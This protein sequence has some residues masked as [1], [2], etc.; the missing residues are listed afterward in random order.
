[1]YSWV[2]VEPI[3]VKSRVHKRSNILHFKKKMGEKLFWEGGICNQI[4]NPLTYP[5]Y[6]NK[7]SCTRLC[8]G[9]AMWKYCFQ[10]EILEA[11]ILPLRELK[12]HSGL[13][14]LFVKDISIVANIHRIINS[15]P[16]AWNWLIQILRPKA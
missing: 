2:P 5:L 13:F 10:N 11:S 16:L 15:V 7:C 1:M 12:V 9:L 3:T 4:I 14:S 8:L 6:L